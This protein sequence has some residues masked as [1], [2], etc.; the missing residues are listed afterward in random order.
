MSDY[1]IHFCPAEMYPQTRDN[2]REMCMNEVDEEGQFC[3]AHEA[4][5]RADEAYDTYRENLRKE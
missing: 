4:D 5:D 2:P 1:P 3:P